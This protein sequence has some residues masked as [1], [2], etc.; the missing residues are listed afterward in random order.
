MTE[1]AEQRQEVVRKRVED[2]LR[3]SQFVGDVL[4]LFFPKMADTITVMMGGEAIEGQDA[5][6]TVDENSVALDPPKLS[7]GPED[8][9]E[10]IR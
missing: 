1:F 7:R 10:I 4:D 5:Y 2:R 8:R 9:D 3:T 6:P